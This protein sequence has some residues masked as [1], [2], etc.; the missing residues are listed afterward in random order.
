[1]HPVSGHQPPSPGDRG[2]AGMRIDRAERDQDVRVLG[3]LVGDA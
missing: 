1:M 3:G 2:L